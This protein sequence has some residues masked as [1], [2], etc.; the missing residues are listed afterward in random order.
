[1]QTINIM[2]TGK[3]SKHEYHNEKQ[4]KFWIEGLGLE[5]STVSLVFAQIY[6]STQYSTLLEAKLLG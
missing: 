1:M 4:S 3:Q 2:A 5:A 6:T